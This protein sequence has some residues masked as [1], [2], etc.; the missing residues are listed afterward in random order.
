MSFEELIGIPT[1][2]PAPIP[3]TMVK[4]ET[5][6]PKAEDLFSTEPSKKMVE[7]FDQ[8]Y[9]KI[10]EDFLP[11]VTTIL[12]AAP[13]PFLTQWR[14]D[15]G[16][17]EADRLMKEAAERGS[18]THNLFAALVT[19]KKVIFNRV[20]DDP[21]FLTCNE[22]FVQL[23]LYKLVKFFEAVKPRVKKSEEIIYSRSK[24]Y[25]GTMDLLLSVPD[26]VYKVNGTNPV[27]LEGGTYVAD[28]KTGKTV[29][30]TAF[31]QTA[32]YAHAW[33]EMTG[34]K[35]SGTIILHTQSQNKNGIEGF[36]TKIRTLDEMKTDYE[37]FLK[38]YEV[39]KIAPWPAKPKIVTDLPEVLSLNM[40]N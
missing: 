8:H 23:A 34:E 30:E 12:S 35:I 11:S 27:R 16:N 29:D 15:I 38:V 40:I 36:G 14:G 21:N 26:G 24:G 22:Q 39:W 19:G 5:V 13:K 33:E 6:F 32:A 4:T 3:V 7:W 17:Q 9:Y 1:P 25:A 18:L 28:I 2:K 10:G 37:N 20:V 31:W